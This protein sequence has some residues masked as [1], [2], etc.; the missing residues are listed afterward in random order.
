MILRLD[1]LQTELRPPSTPDPIGAAAV[2][3]LLGGKFGEMSTFMN[4]TYQSF[5][6]VTARVPVPSTTS[7]PASPPRSSATSSSSPPRSTP[8]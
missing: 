6:S 8:C 1:R 5:T 2:Q 4:Y 3:E 7:S